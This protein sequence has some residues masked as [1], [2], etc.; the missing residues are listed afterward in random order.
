MTVTYP[1]GHI[2][3]KTTDSYIN[4]INQTDALAAYTEYD[5]DFGTK[6]SFTENKDAEPK[7]SVISEILPDVVLSHFEDCVVV[8]GSMTG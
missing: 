2:P 4:D 1:K 5:E 7:E 8:F 3:E 6:Q